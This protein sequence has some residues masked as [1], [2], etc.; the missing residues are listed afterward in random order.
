MGGPDGFRTD[1][2]ARCD[3]R[4]KGGA[5]WGS[6]GAALVGYESRAGEHARVPPARPDESSHDA[7][8]S[9]TLCTFIESSMLSS[10]VDISRRALVAGGLAMAS[11]SPAWPVTGALP[12]ASSLP[13]LGLGSCCDDYEQS[14]EM[15]LG[16][17][18]TGFR[19]IDTAAHYESEAAVGAALVEA[20]RRG[21]LADDEHART[22]TKIW[23]DD[24]GYES[25]LASAKRSMRQLQAER[26][27]VLLIH[28]PGPIDAVQSPASNRKLRAETW[29][30]CE[31]LLRDGLVRRVGVS[32]WTARHLRETL[33][34]CVTPPQVL[35]TELHPRL[36]QLDLVDFARE[37]GVDT[38]MA[39]CPLAH[40]S[41]ALLRSPTLLNMFQFSSFYPL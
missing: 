24:M 36:P 38:I 39:H 9:H 14:F 2:A 28:F 12:S 29:R 41:P 5:R 16:A 37:C 33:A 31:A 11:V 15:V 13:P 3:A 26:L 7:T 18:R 19:L 17:L 4:G 35:Q 23:F 40:G 34:S 20:R 8:S 21:I 27:D 1:C 6:W 25:A 32:N 22:V 30:A 10:P